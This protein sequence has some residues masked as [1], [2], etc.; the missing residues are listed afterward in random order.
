MRGLTV[1]KT[2]TVNL[3]A[4]QWELYTTSYPDGCALAAGEI[5]DAIEAAVN[6]GKTRAEVVEAVDPVFEQFA[7]L[8]ARDTEPRWVFNALLT[9]I[10][11][12]RRKE[13]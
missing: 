2:V 6:A 4:D 8:G 7:H 3:T 12:E 10:F 9:D 13:W 1:H 5:N 11:G